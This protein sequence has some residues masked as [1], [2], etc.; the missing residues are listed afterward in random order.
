MGLQASYY[1]VNICVS[2]VLCKNVG[3]CKFNI[4]VSKLIHSNAKVEGCNIIHCVL[5]STHL[6]KKHPVESRAKACLSKINDYVCVHLQYFCCTFKL[7][8]IVPLRTK[9]QTRS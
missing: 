2:V 7:R 8:H 4:Y 5:V 6:V 1:H 3:T 9:E